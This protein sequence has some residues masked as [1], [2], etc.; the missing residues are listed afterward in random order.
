MTRVDDNL[1]YIIVMEYKINFQYHYILTKLTV[2][3][4]RMLLIH[5]EC[6]IL[7][8]GNK[9]NLFLRFLRKLQ[10]HINLTEIYINL[11]IGSGGIYYSHI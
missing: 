3:F 5:I 6:D 8:S 7:R 10:N 1:I 2:T 4:I 9:R 11:K